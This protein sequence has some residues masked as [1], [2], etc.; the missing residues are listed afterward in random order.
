[1]PL[2]AKMPN[3]T[4]VKHDDGR[5]GKTTAYLPNMQ[6]AGG[7]RVQWDSDAS[8]GEVRRSQLDPAGGNVSIADY[9]NAVKRVTE[10]LGGYTAKAEGTWLNNGKAVQSM[11]I[12][13]KPKHLAAGEEMHAH[14]TLG[15]GMQKV[16]VKC[17]NS[18][19]S[20]Y[21]DGTFTKEATAKDREWVAN[22]KLRNS[23]IS[24]KQVY[25]DGKEALPK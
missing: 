24:S 8:E 16:H 23:L 11:L 20:V 1:M 4:R 19:R 14:A 21:Q 5:T 22:I 10:R 13:S 17:G 18:Y 3:G 6:P 25:L 12:V 15:G 7:Y 2:A 9:D